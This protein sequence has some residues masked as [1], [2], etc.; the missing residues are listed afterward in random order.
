M[1]L[2]EYQFVFGGNKQIQTLVM[3]RLQNPNINFVL[4]LLHVFGS[5][6]YEDRSFEL[7]VLKALPGNYFFFSFLFLDD[8]YV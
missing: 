1:L 5:G 6:E 4:N 8:V 2:I 7:I 3:I